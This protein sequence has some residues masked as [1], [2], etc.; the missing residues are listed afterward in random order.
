V[1][2]VI[3]EGGRAAGVALANGDELRAKTVMSAADPK[4]T[5]LQF[6]ES[7]HFPD[8]FTQAIKNFRVRGSSGK[9]NLALNALPDFTCLPGEG[10]LPSRRNLD[11]SRAST[12]SSARTTKPNTARSRRIR[13]ST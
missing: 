7:K 10:P 13:T 2:Q 11:Q 12:T 5:F 1:Q 8:E 6:V 9:V 4:R 3:V